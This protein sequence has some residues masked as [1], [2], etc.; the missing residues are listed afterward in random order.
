MGVIVLL[1]TARREMPS[2]YIYVFYEVMYLIERRKLIIVLYNQGIILLQK[3][4]RI[5]M[6]EPLEG[7]TTVS[8]RFTKHWSHGFHQLHNL[9]LSLPRLSMKIMPSTTWVI[10]ILSIFF[11]AISAFMTISSSLYYLNLSLNILYFILFYFQ[12]WL[13]SSVWLIIIC[14]ELGSRLTQWRE[15]SMLPLM[16]IICLLPSHCQNG[17]DADGSPWL[18]LASL[19]HLTSFQVTFLKETL[20]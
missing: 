12:W 14:C 20:R 7:A 16:L 6:E 2:A 15:R 19:H 8:T 17:Q 18:T 11:V 4:C 1:S 13:G 5:I 9:I 10:F 3:F